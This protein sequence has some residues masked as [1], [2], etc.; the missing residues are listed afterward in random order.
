MIQYGFVKT[1][2]S[3]REAILINE[4]LTTETINYSFVDK[5]VMIIIVNPDRN[6]LIFFI[7]EI[8]NMYKYISISEL[9]VKQ[10]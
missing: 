6:Y 4:K 3:R 10:N 8:T 5:I 2:V 9:A 7:K 1:R